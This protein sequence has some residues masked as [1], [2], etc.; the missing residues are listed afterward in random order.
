MV[1]KF[2]HPIACAAFLAAGLASPAALSAALSADGETCGEETPCEL[3]NGEY[4]IHLPQTLA[5]IR[6]S[7]EPLGAIFYL[8]GHRG[9]ALNAVRNKGFQRMADELGV[10]FVAVQGING[11][12][13][14]PTAPRN[15]RDEAVFFDAVLQDLSDRFGVDRHRTLLSGFSSGGFMTWYLACA[16]S[17][18]FAGY[19]PIAGA[20]WEPLPR[21]C[22][23][24][25]PYLFHVHGTADTVVPL[26]GRWLG[27]GKWKQ[28][29]V[30][31]SFDV[32]RR[33]S[34]LSGTAPQTET[35]GNLKC[36][37][38]QPVTGVLELCLH[39]GGHSV[40]AGWIRRAWE[41]LAEMKG[42]S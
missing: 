12:W 19:A 32:W 10:A 22:P 27:G 14:F 35:D 1:P 21:D 4:F 40:Q 25:A 38:W 42:W 41:H 33:Q 5:E 13:S 6:K 26:E 23:T 3:E 36:E 20:F 16:D 31:Q 29:D 8:H 15:L 18:R 17:G 28:G 9:K 39:D 30:S 24:E 37:R 2:L 34:G 7:G 11:T